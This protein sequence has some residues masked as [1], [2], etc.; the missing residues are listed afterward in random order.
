[1][2]DTTFRAEDQHLPQRHR[3]QDPS[4]MSVIGWYLQSAQCLWR[5]GFGSIPRAVIHAVKPSTA[6]VLSFRWRSRQKR[7]KLSPLVLLQEQ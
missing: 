3:L 7:E 6:A 2:A 5:T 1:M 4:A